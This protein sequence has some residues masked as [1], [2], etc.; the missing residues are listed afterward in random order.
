MIMAQWVFMDA[1]DTFI[2]GYPTLYRAIQD[3][4]A[5]AEQ[6]E[7]HE[8]KRLVKQYKHVAN[9]CDLTSQTGFETYFRGLYQYVLEEL[10]YKKDSAQ[11]A[12]RLW[13]LWESGRH[14]RLFDDSYLA[15]STL[16]RSGYHLGIISNWDQSLESL[17]KRWGVF[18]MFSA[19]IR[20]T[21]VGVMKPDERIFEMALKKTG[22]KAET[23]WYLGD[24][25]DV[26][27]I[28][29]KKTGMKTMLVDYYGKNEA[30]GEADYLVPSM[31]V[32]AMVIQKLDGIEID[33]RNWL[34]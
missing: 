7:E 13:Q 28:P 8:I 11:Q 17:L 31:S 23:C 1:G 21:A 2:Y 19:C 5:D 30:A 20:S 33:Y 15:L 10:N 32:A 24:Q 3:C 22:V 16:K 25:V 12:E 34:D 6:P 14:L 4:W 27:I 18:D 26:D 9:E 29:A